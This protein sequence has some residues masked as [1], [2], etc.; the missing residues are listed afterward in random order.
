MS[1]INKVLLDLDNRTQGG[2]ITA[3]QSLFSNLH[4]VGV[5]SPGMLLRWAW[6]LIA[7]LAIFAAFSGGWYYLHRVR[8]VPVEPVTK[9]VVSS[10][11]KVKHI[12]DSAKAAGDPP[13]APV[14][15]VAAPKAAPKVPNTKPDESSHASPDGNAAPRKTMLPSAPP[16]A[17]K[18]KH[19]ASH[20]AAAKVAAP[21]EDSSLKRTLRPLRPEERAES[22]YL[23]GVSSIRSGQEREGENALRA[24]LAINPAHIEARETLSV[25][26]LQERHFEQAKQVLSEGIEVAPS[27][28]PFSSRLARLYLE[29]GDEARALQLLESNRARVTPD[30]EYL[31]MLGTLYQRAAK[32]KDARDAFRQALSLQPDQG[33]WWMGL[34]ISLEALRDWRAARDAYQRCLTSAHTD[35]RVHQYAEQRLSIT[36]RYLH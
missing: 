36:N 8:F 34:G 13:S 7:G 30:A 5:P 12:A 35:P 9:Q 11:E 23:K 1:L 32:P 10:P 33:R 21:E 20:S 14:P 22:L 15:V 29:Q 6:T 19:V 25:V 26:L 18:P 3:S 24:A 2:A 27:Y 16:T 17:P 28:A 4:P 31:G